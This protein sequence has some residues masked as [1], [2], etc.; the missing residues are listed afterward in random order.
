MSLEHDP[1]RAK[2]SGAAGLNL[3]KGASAIAEHLGPDFTPRIVRYLHDT[4][5]LTSIFQLG[6]TGPLMAQPDQLAEEIRRQG[7]GSE[8]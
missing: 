3:L 5:K 7:S 4:G 1:A 6:G 8:T 2:G